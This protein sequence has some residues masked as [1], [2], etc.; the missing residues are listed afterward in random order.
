[1][2]PRRIEIR[3]NTL[4]YVQPYSI[5]DVVQG[6]TFGHYKSRDLAEKALEQMKAHGVDKKTESDIIHGDTIEVFE[7]RM[8]NPSGDQPSDMSVFMK[9]TRKIRLD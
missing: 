9:P 6:K 2:A 8:K 3:R 1:M 5:V 7:K 4:P